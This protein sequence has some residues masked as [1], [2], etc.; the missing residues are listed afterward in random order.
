VYWFWGVFRLAVD[1]EAVERIEII[2]RSKRTGDNMYD[3]VTEGEESRSGVEG[4]VVCHIVSSERPD[5]VRL[6]AAC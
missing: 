2:W 6:L 1:Y 3:V 4:V 5:A